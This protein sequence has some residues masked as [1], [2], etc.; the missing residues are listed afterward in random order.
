M[1]VARKSRGSRKSR[2]GRLGRHHGN[3]SQLARARKT[4]APVAFGLSRPEIRAVF[5]R[6]LRAHPGDRA[7][8]YNAALQEIAGPYDRNMAEE[9]HME[10]RVLTEA[11]HRMMDTEPGVAQPDV[12]EKYKAMT[13][14]P[15]KFEGEAAYV[16]YFYEQ[17]LDGLGEQRGDGTLFHVTAQDRDV[18]PELKGRRTIRIRESDDGFVYGS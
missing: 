1:A 7:N 8:A 13:R 3:A 9:R 2:S 4:L 15:G 18:F 14:H 6:H 10:R 5:L 11:L 12:R 17:F 16:P